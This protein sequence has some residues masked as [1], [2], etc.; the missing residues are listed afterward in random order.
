MLILQSLLANIDYLRWLVNLFTQI[1][2][3]QMLVPRFPSPRRRAVRRH[4]VRSRHQADQGQPV[5]QGVNYCPHCLIDCINRPLSIDLFIR[6]K[7]RRSF[8][9]AIIMPRAHVQSHMRALV[10]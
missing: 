7:C 1:I 9:S 5:V 2:S 6:K 8:L 3:I 4:R 10:S